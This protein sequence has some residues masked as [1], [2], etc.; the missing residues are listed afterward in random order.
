MYVLKQ[1]PNLPVILHFNVTN[2]VNL[3]GF[4]HFGMR[5]ARVITL[6]KTISVFRIPG[7]Q[8]SALSMN[9]DH[10]CLG[11]KSFWIH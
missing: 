9:Y 3:T 4:S 11:A 5:K 1:V 2:I 6:T 10:F 8:S 7:N